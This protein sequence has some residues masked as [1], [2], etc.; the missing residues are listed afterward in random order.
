M[1]DMT[2]FDHT[3]WCGDLNYRIEPP[4]AKK[5]KKKEG[6]KNEA[7]AVVHTLVKKDDFDGLW[8]MDELQ[9]EVG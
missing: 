4:A 3:F 9:R 7:A 8:A 2:Q 5:G 1:H 6:N